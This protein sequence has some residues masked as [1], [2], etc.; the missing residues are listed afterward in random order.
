[1]KKKD[2]VIVKKLLAIVLLL[3]IGSVVGFENLDDFLDDGVI[4]DT[5]SD[6]QNDYTQK[7]DYYIASD[8]ELKVYF[9]DVGQADSIFVMSSGECMLIDAGNNADGKLIVKQLE[10]MNIDTIDYVVG[11]HPHEDHIGG[12]DDVINNFKIKNVLMPKKTTTTKTYE[13]VLKAIKN[14]NLK[15]KTPKVGDVFYVGMAKCEVMGIENDA[16]NLNENSI[17]IELT[18]GE[19]K[20]L[21]TGDAEVANEKLRSWDDIDVLKVAHHGSRTSSSEEFLEQVKPEYVIISCGRDNDYGHPHKEVMDRLKGSEVYQTSK[22]GTIL[23]TSDGENIEV[24]KLSINLDG[25]EK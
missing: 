22:D 23:I 14:A 11:T 8:D 1:M 6:N 12:L 25:T 9:F 16:E 18:Y 19:K 7:E 20:F 17:I 10:N 3:I 2:K 13:D 4:Q 5:V 24:E 21:F 15:I